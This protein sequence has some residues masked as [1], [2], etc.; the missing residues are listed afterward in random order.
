MKSKKLLS[1]IMASMIA[2]T[3][4]VSCSSDSNSR[5]IINESV[6]E[7]LIDIS[8]M[9]YR[10][11]NIGTKPVLVV[12][13]SIENK[14]MKTFT[15]NNDVVVSAQMNPYHIGHYYRMFKSIVSNSEFAENDHKA[16]GIGETVDIER[17]FEIDAEIFDDYYFRGFDCMIYVNSNALKQTKTFKIS[18]NY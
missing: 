9:H 1:L 13:L 4:F 11:I 5:V 16:V 18:F 14:S 6:Q 15:F 7:D 17:A 8:M 2:L 10:I 3:G 12:R